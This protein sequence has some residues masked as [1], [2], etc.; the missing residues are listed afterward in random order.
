MPANDTDTC[1]MLQVSPG[2]DGMGLERPCTNAA[3]GTAESGLR[4]CRPCGEQQIREEFDVRWDHPPLKRP[5]ERTDARDAPEVALARARAYDGYH[6]ARMPD[7]AITDVLELLT[8]VDRLRAANSFTVTFLGRDPSC[9]KHPP[10]EPHAPCW[11]W[12]TVD[13]T[14]GGTFP[15]REAGSLSPAEVLQGLKNLG[16]DVECGSCIEIFYTG[17]STT[18]HSDGLHLHVCSTFFHEVIKTSRP[19]GPADWNRLCNGCVGKAAGLIVDILKHGK[20]PDGSRCA[21]DTDC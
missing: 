14:A 10:G 2:E 5:R 11:K 17:F 15:P 8:E 19:K 6:M 9:T 3:L 7:A 21:N 4:V 1:E 16:V 18:E 20:T 13:P 12:G